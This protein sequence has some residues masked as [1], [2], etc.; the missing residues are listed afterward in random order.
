MEVRSIR[1]SGAV[2]CSSRSE[3]KTAATGSGRRRRRGGSGDGVDGNRRVCVGDGRIW[4]PIG[5]GRRGG[6]GRAPA[7]CRGCRSDRDLASSAGGLLW[8]ARRPGGGDEAEDTGHVGFSRREPISDDGGAGWCSC[9]RQGQGERERD[10]QSKKPNEKWEEE[11]RRGWQA[12]KEEATGALAALLLGCWSRQ[13]LGAE[14]EHGEV[15]TEAGSGRGG[16][17]GVGLGVLQVRQGWRP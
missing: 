12:R 6:I 8:T 3:E 7:R 2:S 10:S 15:E 4:C 13:R 5:S 9:S 1:S 17:H 16:A 14:E 11:R